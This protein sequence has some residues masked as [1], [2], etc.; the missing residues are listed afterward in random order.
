LVLC[1]R[2]LRIDH[3]DVAAVQWSDDPLRVLPLLRAS[4]VAKDQEQDRD[5]YQQEN[6]DQSDSLHRYTTNPVAA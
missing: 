5:E 6:K 3:L 2:H 1:G 4:Y